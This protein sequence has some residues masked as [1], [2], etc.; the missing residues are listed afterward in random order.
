MLYGPN[1]MG[2]VGRATTGV[3]G[4]SPWSEGPSSPAA[5]N[6]F[7]FQRPLSLKNYHIGLPLEI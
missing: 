5:G 3:Q 6:T 1:L 4:Q 7:L 2:C